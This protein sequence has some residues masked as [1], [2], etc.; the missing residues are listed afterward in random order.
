MTSGRFAVAKGMMRKVRGAN[1]SLWAAAVA[2]NAF[3]AL[4]PLTVAVLG[5]AAAIGQHAAAIARIERALDPIAPGRVSDFITGLLREAAD[6][7]QD[8]RGWLI[9]I[10]VA[11]ALAFGSRA[12][13]ALQ[14]ALAVVAGRAEVR[15]AVQA[16]LVGIALTIGGG[17]ALLLASSL[18]VVGRDL[19]SFL[20]NWTGVDWLDEVWVWLRVPVSTIGLYVFI[21]AF[22]A[23][24]PPSPL[25]R[26]WVAAL[27]AT[28]G[29]VAGSLLFG[30]YL[31]WAPDLGPMF[32][33]LG[34]VAVALMWLYLGALAI[35]FG[36]VVVAHAEGCEAVAD[37]VAPGV[38]RS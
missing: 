30:L 2:Y 31:R 7:V 18:L 11:M 34:A 5:V 14:R 38:A 8:G 37:G 17:V 4:V 23:W 33:T 13:V 21:L 29:V 16:R 32:G 15:P 6:R 35:L 27:V 3:L 25:P 36:G 10:S 19:F 22:Y 20:G 1:L 26:A 24:G 9:G 28:A 12:V